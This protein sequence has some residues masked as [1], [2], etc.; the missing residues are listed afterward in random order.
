MLNKNSKKN[1]IDLHLEGKG[2]FVKIDHLNRFI[3]E[4]PPIDLRKYA[5]LKLADIFLNR[6]MFI[7]AAKSFRSAAINSVIFK[8]QQENYLKE[9][10]SYIR[11]LMFEDANTALKKALIEANERERNA[12]QKDF[13]IY[14][15]KVGEDLEKK[16]NSGKA[17]QLYEKLIRM[18]ITSEEK[19]EIKEKL[20]KIYEKLGKIKEYNFL[21]GM[22]SF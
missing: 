4:Q 7:D 8:E 1:E 15:K 20:L 3:K 16:G 5:Y 14:F 13:I 11:A 10:K 2:D 21:K 12:L 17:L 18:K 22:T 19:M 6:E 9:A